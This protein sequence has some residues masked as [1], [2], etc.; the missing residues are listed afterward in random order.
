MPGS[1][2]ISPGPRTF[3][4]LDDLGLMVAGRFLTAQR[5]V[6]GR[7]APA[8][9]EDPF[10][11]SCGAQGASRG[12]VARRPAHVPAGCRPA[13][14]VG[15]ARR[16]ACPHCRRVRRQHTPAPARPRAPLPRSA[17]ER[18]LR[19]PALEPVPACRVARTPETSRHT[20]GTTIPASAQAAL[21]D[22]PHRLDDVE[23][24]GVDK[25]VRRHTRRD[26]RYA[27]VITVIVDPTP[28]TRCHRSGPFAGHGPGPGPGRSSG[29][30]S[31]LRASP[32]VNGSRQ[33]RLTTPPG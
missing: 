18:G 33:W 8:G 10:R 9:F 19:A 11:R 13:Q 14:P 12:T 7:R 1:A 3:L 16:L 15:C 30:D 29:P 23:V 4:G 28:G 32:G 25:H 31:P 27:T 24:P 21:P 5:T 17:A 6:A 20:A 22:D 2:F 26:N